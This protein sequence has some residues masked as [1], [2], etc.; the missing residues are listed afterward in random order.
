MM[1]KLLT[2]VT[3]VEYDNE[4]LFARAE[5]IWNMERCYN[6]LEVGRCKKDD[7]Q[8][9]HCHDARDGDWTTGTKIDPVRFEK[10]LDRYYKLVGWDENGIPTREKLLELGLDKYNERIKEIRARGGHA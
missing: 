4:S 3:G 7:M 10:L 5:K 1:A 6:V 8:I 2:A 9:I